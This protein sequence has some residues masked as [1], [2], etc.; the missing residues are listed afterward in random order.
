MNSEIQRPDHI[1]LIDEPEPAQRLDSYLHG[2]FADYSRS[3]LKKQ[4]TEGLVLVND[5]QVKPSYEVKWG[6]R[7]SV[8]L[9]RIKPAEQLIPQSMPLDLLYEDEHI[10][11][12]NKA[13]GVVVHPGAGNE[14]NTLVHG[15]LAHCPKLAM[16]GAPLRPGIVHRLDK[17]TSGAMV[18]AKSERA[19]LNL[20]SQFKRR[21]VRKQYL[22]L[23]HGSFEQSSG[24]ICA[25]LGRHPTDRKK[26]AVIEGRGREAITRWQVKKQWN[27]SATLLLVTIETGRT[28]QIRVHLS[29]LN[30]PVMGDEIYGGGKKR[31]QAVKPKELHDLLMGISRQMLH[32]WCLSFLHPICG[33]RLDMEAPLPD[34]FL[35]L[36]ASLDRVTSR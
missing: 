24:E 10:L 27:T 17:D 32:A 34:D 1:I 8:W 28:H 14:E 22:A 9:P 5:Q 29:Y 25:C 7:I 16:Q 13:A 20:I 19:Y 18:V 4:I 23:V 31:F 12:I 21:E 30:H 6:D 26:I 15:L 33:A 35:R 36:M 2:R 3:Q 11:V